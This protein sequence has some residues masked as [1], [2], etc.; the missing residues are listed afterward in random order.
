MPLSSTQS[1]ETKKETLCSIISITDVIFAT[2]FVSVSLSLTLSF[3]RKILNQQHKEKTLTERFFS[4][5]HVK[6]LFV[7]TLFY[8]HFDFLFFSP[9][10]ATSLILLRCF[11][12]VSQQSHWMLWMCN[13]FFFLS[14]SSFHCEQ[15]SKAFM[16]VLLGVWYVRIYVCVCLCVWCVTAPRMAVFMQSKWHKYTELEIEMDT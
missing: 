16:Y 5:S 3:S 10:N 9:R 14:L 1:S 15:K 11:Y 12:F 13:S 8:F 7:I 2:F 4:G 6:L